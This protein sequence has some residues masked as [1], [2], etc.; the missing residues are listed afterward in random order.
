MNHFGINNVLN[1]YL[2]ESAFTKFLSIFQNSYEKSFPIKTKIIS[3]KDESHPWIT[4]SHLKDMK[5]RDKLCRLSKKKKIDKKTYTDFRN[6]L[7]ERLRVSKGEYYNQLFEFHKNNTKKTWEVINNVIRTKSSTRPKIIL[8]DDEGNKYSENEIPSKFLDYYTSIA[9][10]LTAEIPTS[11]SDAASYLTNRMEL[12][13][14]MSP[15]SP[16]EVDTII[17]EMKNNGKN[18]NTIST[19]VLVNSKHIINPILCHLT[20]LFVEQG[21]FPDHLKTGCISP[22]FKG[23][24]REKIIITDQF[25]HSFV[26]L[27]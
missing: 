4:E 7:N 16:I 13:F 14:Q 15:I 9:D 2:A 19:T 27:Y 23:G 3:Q 26:E 11:Q 21:Y 1:D 22:I 5:E 18:P 25:A 24:D 17:D 8:S 10:K 20:N 6:N 12:D